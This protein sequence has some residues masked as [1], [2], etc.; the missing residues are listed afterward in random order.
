MADTTVQADLTVTGN[1]INTNLTNL[2][3]QMSKLSRTQYSTYTG[4]AGG[5]RFYKM[6]D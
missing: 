3:N 4:M 2:T 1:I 5:T 6:E